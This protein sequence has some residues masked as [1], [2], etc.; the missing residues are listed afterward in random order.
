MFCGMYIEWYGTRK[1]SDENLYFLKNN[2]QY[3]FTAK[4]GQHQK[5]KTTQSEMNGFF[6]SPAK[7]PPPPKKDCKQKPGNNRKN[8]FMYQML[9]KDIIQEDK[10]A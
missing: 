10:A 6:S 4:I 2:F 8:G 3:Y 5:D 1:K 9:G 7:M